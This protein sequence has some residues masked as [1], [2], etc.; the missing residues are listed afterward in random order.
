MAVCEWLRMNIRNKRYDKYGGFHIS[1]V[2][3]N[4]AWN[5]TVLE[6]FFTELFNNLLPF[7]SENLD[8]K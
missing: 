1:V 7:A 6:K 5:H 3:F 8:S 2:K 4:M